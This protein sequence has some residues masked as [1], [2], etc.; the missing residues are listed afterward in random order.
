LL[1]V[2]LSDPEYRR[3]F[4]EIRDELNQS[5]GLICFARSWENPVLWGHYA[6]KHAGVALGFE[7][8]NHI[9]VQ[10]IYAKRPANIPI[11]RSTGRP[12]L[13]HQLMNRL[14]RTKFWD[15]KYENEWRVFVQLDH[16]T[17]E[18]GLYFYDFSD[19]LRLEEVILGPRCALPIDRVRAMVATFS[20]AVVVRKAR[21]A[22]Q[23]FQVVEDK[24]ASKGADVAKSVAQA[25]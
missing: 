21:I 9:P 18:A 5:K 2:N 4:R 15:W 22:F 7:I 8:P 10:A 12:L 17:K 23:N 20:P 24:F 1:A 25:E 3:A 13:D 11:N 14:L 6:D 16:G 19:D